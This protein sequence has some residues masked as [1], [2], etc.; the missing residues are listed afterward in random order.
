MDI[1][2]VSPF[3]NSEAEAQEQGVCGGLAQV[4]ILH[5]ARTQA[6]E[7]VFL[8]TFFTWLPAS[9]SVAMSL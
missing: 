5:S 9:L 2:A 4:T 7:L 8:T 3:L 6:L 1:T